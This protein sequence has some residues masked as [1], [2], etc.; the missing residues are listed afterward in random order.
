MEIISSVNGTVEE[1]GGV[2]PSGMGMAMGTAAAAPGSGPYL[3][4]RHTHGEKEVN[5]HGDENQC[6][7]CC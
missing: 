4:Q 5:H 6:I 1:G 2:T 7:D 3:S